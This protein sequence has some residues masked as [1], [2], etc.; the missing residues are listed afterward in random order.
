MQSDIQNSDRLSNI[1][2]PIRAQLRR[3]PFHRIDTL[4]TTTARFWEGKTSVADPHLAIMP[5][6]DLESH[7]SIRGI[8]VSSCSGQAGQCSPQYAPS[9]CSDRALYPKLY[10]CIRRSEIPAFLIYRAVSV[11]I[12]MGLDVNSGLSKGLIDTVVAWRE[13]FYV[14]VVEERVCSC[15]E[16]A[17]EVLHPWRV[18]A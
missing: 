11:G 9:H 13:G 5:V 14:T 3:I 2:S 18:R 6:V 17:P 16:G 4:C 12:D 1:L 15:P 7:R 8:V 10:V